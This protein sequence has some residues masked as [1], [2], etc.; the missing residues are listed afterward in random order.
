MRMCVC[1]RTF[2]AP[3][4]ACLRTAK[5]CL[6]C[7]SLAPCLPPSSISS[8]RGFFSRPAAPFKTSAGAAILTPTGQTHDCHCDQTHARLPRGGQ[9]S[10][11]SGLPTSPERL[12]GSVGIIQLRRPVNLS[13]ESIG[14]T[15]V[16]E[17]G[18]R[19][20]EIQRRRAAGSGQKTNWLHACVF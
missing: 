10:R 7:V 16:W 18:Q 15:L 3:A 8:P 4:R 20:R 12:R 6:H 14:D 17:S 11:A 19:G 1:V 2:K 13:L 5:F 9:G